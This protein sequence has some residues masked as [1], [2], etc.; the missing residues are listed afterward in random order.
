MTAVLDSHL[1]VWDVSRGGYAW[2]GPQH[3]PLHR[4]F[5]PDEAADVLSASGISSAILVQAEDSVADTEFLLAAAREWPFVEGVV[6]WVQLDD[7]AAAERQLAAHLQAPAF[8]G[9]RHLVHD[10]P[11]EGFLH[12]PEVRE[13]LRLLADAGLPLDVPD[14]WPRHLSQLPALADALP[15]LVIVVDHLAKPPRGA[16]Q[17]E[18]RAWAAGL[19]EVAA[20]PHTVAKLSGLQVAGQ[21]FSVQALA[22]VWDTAL[23]CFGPSRLM[24][25]GDWPMTVPAGGYDAHW[26]VVRELVAALSRTE[27]EQVLEGTA[28]RTYRLAPRAERC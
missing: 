15:D 7:P 13:S 19:R 25:G 10:D 20:R 18:R 28:R 8:R 3:G 26:T 21:P 23:D 24:Y 17:E 14:A 27:Q 22:E 16:L 2:L 12:L 4:S 6:G 11:R 1:H 9:V 5:L